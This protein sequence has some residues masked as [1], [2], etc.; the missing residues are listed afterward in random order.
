MASCAIERMHRGD[1]GA[2]PALMTGSD[3]T[4]SLGLFT[5][6]VLRKHGCFCPNYFPA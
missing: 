1:K 5:I 2:F 3:C 6:D 4:R